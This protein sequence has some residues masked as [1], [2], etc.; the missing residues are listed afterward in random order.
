[1]VQRAHCPRAASIDERKRARTRE[2]KCFGGVATARAR[3]GSRV[4]CAGCLSIHTDKHADFYY[5]LK[6]K[7]KNKGVMFPTTKVILTS[8]EI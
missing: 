2:R 8:R 3:V 1:M 7:Y 6:I 5:R 4:D